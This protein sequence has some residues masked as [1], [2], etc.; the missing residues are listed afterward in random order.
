MTM[1]AGMMPVVEDWLRKAVR[2][3][4]AYAL[5]AD[6][7]TAKPERMYTR[8]EVCNILKISKPTLWQKTKAGEIEPTRAGRR[9]LYTESA[10]KKYMEG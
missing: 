9:V 8:A 6:R 10:I 5:A 7:E 2:E 3:E 1:F 4:V